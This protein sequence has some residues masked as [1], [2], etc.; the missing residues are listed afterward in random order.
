MI[1]DLE[2]A[3]A[4]EN[5]AAAREAI[6]AADLD[7]A[8]VIVRVNE[9]GIARLR[10]RPRGSPARYPTIMVPKA[11]RRLLDAMPAG[12]DVDR[13]VRV[14][15]RRRRRAARWRHRSARSCGA[16]RISSRRSAAPR[17]VTPT[18]ATGMSRAPPART[19]CSPRV[20]PASRRSTPCTST[21]S[22][23]D[24]LRAEAEDAAASGFA[25]TA[26]I[27]PSHAEVIRDGVPADGRAGRVGAAGSGCRGGER[28]RVPLRGRHGRR[29]GAAPCRGRGAPSAA[30]RPG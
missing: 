25:A 22:D 2:D 18:A 17:A 9:V 3:V 16:P 30:S 29:P 13:A 23:L 7:P 15:G 10:R 11:D 4:P 8:R 26:C 20:R 24:G 21:S 14:G 28:G 1:L 6:A 27:H 5:R 19:C 12:F